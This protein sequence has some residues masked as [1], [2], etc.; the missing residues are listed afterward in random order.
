V[1]TALEAGYEL[2]ALAL[3][4]V[5]LA[6]LL[7][8]KDVFGG[9]LRAID[10]SFF[11]AR[12]LHG[13]VTGAENAVIGALDEAIKGVERRAAQ[14]ESGLIDSLALLI[15]VPLLLGLG[16][17]GALEYLWN[18]A[19]RPVIH[20]ITDTIRAAANSALTKVEALEKT[21]ATNVGA[22]ERYAREHALSALTDAESYV[23]TQLRAAEGTLRRDIAAAKDKAEGYADLAV[24]RL[25]AAEDAAVA[26]AVALAGAAKTAGLEAAQAAEQA[27]ERAAGSAL[28]Q[29][30]AA[31]AKALA[32]AEAAAR[33]ALAGV[34]GIAVGAADDLATIE[35]DLGALGVAGLI[36][37]IPALATLVHAI[38]TEAGL[39]SAACRRKVKGIC[40]TDPLAWEEL[41]LGLAALGFGF[42][43]AEVAE[44]A[45]RGIGEAGGLLAE[46]AS[47]PGD[48]LE[49]VGRAI[50]EVTAAL[51]A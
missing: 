51:A 22:A 24:S 9:L 36:A 16:V 28:A 17:K 7:V 38:A 31:A 48:A 2:G 19:L 21:V 5:A 29:S 8:A 3:C 43:L 10:F 20:S 35:R 13:L 25:R 6:L 44:A 49:R 27:A 34:R 47:V 18:H 40:G 37:A 41:L 42:N 50:G 12:P 26:G 46:V 23:D 30:E 32:E 15:A 14:F 1:G 39:D 33:V 4:F 45:A 11:G